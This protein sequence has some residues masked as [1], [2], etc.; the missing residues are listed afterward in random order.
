MIS[1][2][3]MEK[4]LLLHTSTTGALWNIIQTDLSAGLTYVILFHFRQLEACD[5]SPDDPL[6][7]P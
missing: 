2:T 5:H 6:E 4:N 7:G 3:M 1:S